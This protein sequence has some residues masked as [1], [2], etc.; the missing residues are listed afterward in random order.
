MGSSSF[1]VVS[2]TIRAEASSKR[3]RIRSRTV[4]RLELPLRLLPCIFTL[5]LLLGL[6][7]RSSHAEGLQISFHLNPI[8]GYLQFLGTISGSQAGGEQFIELFRSS[9]FATPRHLALLE[10]FRRFT[11][12]SK[13]YDA[14]RFALTAMKSR[15]FADFRTRLEGSISV[16]ERKSLFAILETFLPIYDELVWNPS[17]A[18]MRRWQRDLVTLMHRKHLPRRFLLVRHFLN[19]SWPVSRELR[20]FLYPIPGSRGS[21]RSRSYGHAIQSVGVLTDGKD[22]A[23]RLGVVFHEIAHTLLDSRAPAVKKKVEQCFRGTGRGEWL[24]LFCRFFE[25]LPTM[26]G[27]A[28]V[29]ELLRARLDE[30]P[31]YNDAIIDTMARSLYPVFLKA[32]KT[33]KRLDASFIKDALDRFTRSFPDWELDFRN[34]FCAVHLITDGRHFVHSDV[35]ARIRR[36]FPIGGYSSFSRPIGHPFTLRAAKEKSYANVVVVH[37]DELKALQILVESFPEFAPFSRQ[38]LERPSPLVF[39]RLD[40]T[41]KPFIVFRVETAAQLDALLDRLSHQGHV[42]LDAPFLPPPCSLQR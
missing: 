6:V 15:S 27:N 10:D 34:V 4:F 24:P 42:D 9:P 14:D 21:T 22:V 7:P 28:W 29:P 39:A 20:I 16:L 40:S 2:S 36:S 32:L 11:R 41:R 26:A 30:A 17:R 23:T 18:K 37:A 31:L 38:L 1:Q 19:S 5:S 25:I 33:G 3:T 12:R 35:L 8:H 13:S